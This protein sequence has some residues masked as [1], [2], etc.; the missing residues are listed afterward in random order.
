VILIIHNVKVSAISKR[1]AVLLGAGDKTGGSE[2]RYYKRLI[3]NAD[4]R[5]ERHIADRGPKTKR[6][7]KGKGHEDL[8]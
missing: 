5:Y 1:R 6:P 2:K 4:A 8:A 3:E 7:G